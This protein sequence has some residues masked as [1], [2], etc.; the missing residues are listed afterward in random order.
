MWHWLA[1]NKL[2]DEISSAELSNESDEVA[3]I[4]S[5]AG[6]VSVWKTGAIVA[7]TIVGEMVDW[8][9]WVLV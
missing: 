5:G 2:P 1:E 8:S 3:K 7:S 9:T 4:F 6:I